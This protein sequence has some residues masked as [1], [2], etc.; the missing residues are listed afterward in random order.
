MSS[1]KAETQGYACA[2][3]KRQTAAQRVG[4]AL[5]HLPTA[6]SQSIWVPCRQALW[7]VWT[8]PGI[9]LSIWSETPCGSRACNPA[10]GAA[11]RADLEGRLWQAGETSPGGNLHVFHWRE[12][13]Q[14]WL[15]HSLATA[16]YSWWA[17]RVRLPACGVPAFVKRLIFFAI[18]L[19]VSVFV[20]CESTVP[21]WRTVLVVSGLKGIPSLSSGRQS[22]KPPLTTACVLHL[23]EAAAKSCGS[24]SKCPSVF[25]SLETATLTI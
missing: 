2:S 14:T 24:S 15:L 10:V 23:S 18:F 9:W 16:I 25:L 13:W 5:C 7:H 8:S 22:W 4:A 3:Q 6:H 17:V 12:S 1:A 19:S 11:G 20:L 21:A